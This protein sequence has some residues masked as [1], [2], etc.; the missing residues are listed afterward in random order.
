V[1]RFINLK[2]QFSMNVTTSAAHQDANNL[3]VQPENLYTVCSA[4]KTI[5][6]RSL[7]RGSRNS[8][9]LSEYVVIHMV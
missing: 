4:T 8:K 6:H 5:N 9:S 1:V 3:L 2:Q 7:Q